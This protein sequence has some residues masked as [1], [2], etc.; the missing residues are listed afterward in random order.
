M[1]VIQL[2]IVTDEL[3]YTYNV[4]RNHLELKHPLD[5]IFTNKET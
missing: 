4:N 3:Q 1:Y 2:K 5:F